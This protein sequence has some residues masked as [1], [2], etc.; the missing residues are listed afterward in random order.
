MPV[1]KPA[2]GFVPIWATVLAHIEHCALA[3]LF[4]KEKEAITN[5]IRS[6]FFMI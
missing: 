5:K 1:L 6:I 4:I 3:S 2:A